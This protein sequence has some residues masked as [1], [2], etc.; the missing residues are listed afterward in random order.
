MRKGLAYLDLAERCRK[1]AGQVKGAAPQEGIGG[2][3]SIMG[4]SRCRARQTAW[5]TGK[6]GAAQIKVSDVRCVPSADISAVLPTPGEAQ[7]P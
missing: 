1:L 2:D 4:K 7:L 3:G 6:K 5:Q